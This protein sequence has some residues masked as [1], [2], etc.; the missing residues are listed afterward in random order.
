MPRLRYL[1]LAAPLLHSNKDSHVMAD[2][3]PTTSTPTPSA[4]TVTPAIEGLKLDPLA[5][6]EQEAG[7]RRADGGGTLQYEPKPEDYPAAAKITP[8]AE[9]LNGSLSQAV[10]QA[11]DSKL[12][13]QLGTAAEEAQATIDAAIEATDKRFEQERKAK[14]AAQL[15]S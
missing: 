13:A 2:K 11:S 1:S 4:S 10:S 9:Q 5:V 6:R 12:S 15:A 7:T 3:A 8:P 14:V